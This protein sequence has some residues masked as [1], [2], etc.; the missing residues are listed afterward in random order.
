MKQNWNVFSR[1]VAV[2]GALVAVAALVGIGVAWAAEQLPVTGSVNQNSPTHTTTFTTSDGSSVTLEYRPILFGEAYKQIM[3]DEKTREFYTERFLKKVARVTIKGGVYTQEVSIPSGE[4][5]M[6]M[7][8]DGTN[9]FIDLTDL[10]GK[11]VVD[12][13]QMVNVQ[14]SPITSD[15]LCMWVQPFK[16]PNRASLRVM[17]GD[18]AFRIVFNVGQK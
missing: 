1:K 6:A 18:K 17:Y 14:D 12:G 8:T 2:A 5:Y 9:W 16:E 13:G 3:E 11:T 4:Y 7:T 15:R 10:E